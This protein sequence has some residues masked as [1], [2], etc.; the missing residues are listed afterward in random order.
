MQFVLSEKSK[1]G[2]GI[3]IDKRLEKAVEERENEV[4][5]RRNR[6]ELGTRFMVLG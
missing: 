5:N 3:Y 2:K 6:L 1:E 4:R